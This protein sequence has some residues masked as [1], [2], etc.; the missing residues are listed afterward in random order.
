VPIEVL[1]V[2]EGQDRGARFGFPGPEATI[3]RGATMDV[4]LTDPHVS[5]R[6]AAVRVRGDAL[7]LTDLDSA[8]GTRVNGMPIHATTTL[9]VGD[10]VRIGETVLAVLWT[11]AHD[12][13]PATGAPGPAPGA[14]GPGATA[15]ADDGAPTGPMVVTAPPQRRRGP[16]TGPRAVSWGVLLAGSA[17]AAAGLSFVATT[18]PAAGAEGDVRSLWTVAPS[19]LRAMAVLP[20][21]AGVVLAA[22]WLGMELTRGRERERAIAAVAVAA[23]GGAVAGVPLLVAVLPAAAGGG[24]H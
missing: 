20:A 21:L 15:P 9:A 5:R 7:T 22:L 17:L 8:L 2:I 11:P 14:G 12:G 6:H 4:V 3:G 1:E 10:R 19:E 18:M 23:A 24:T 13:G 16:G